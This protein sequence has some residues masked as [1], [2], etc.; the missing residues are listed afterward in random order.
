MTSIQLVVFDMAGTTVRD[1][2]EVLHCFLEAAAAT[3]L[4]AGAAEVNPMMGWPKRRVF[5]TLWQRQLDPDH[6][7]FA[8][9]VEQSFGKF[10]LLLEDHYRTQPVAPTQ[11]CLETFAWLRSHQ[12][13]IALNTGFYREVTTLIL[14]RLGWDQGLDANYL[15][16]ET[17]LIQAS[18]TPSEIYN[19][20]GR[21]APYMIQ[22]AMHQL[23]IQDPQTVAVL[24]DTPADLEAGF[25][26]HCGLVLGV[27]NG[28]HSAAE[29]QSYFHHGLLGSLQELPAQ[30]S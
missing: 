11:G 5:Q 17:S 9:N 22:K 12:I 21:P 18:V 23:G 1:D 27:T 16:S 15:G 10:K 2:N 13:K 19:H 7:D 25:N 3:G 30:L 26:A 8:A 4:T 29:L 6:A 14:Q 20:E 28:T 24:G